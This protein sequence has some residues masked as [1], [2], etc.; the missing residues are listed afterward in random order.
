MFLSELKPDEGGYINEI[1]VSESEKRLLTSLGFNPG[2]Y[3]SAEVRAKAGNTVIYNAL[4][5]KVAL[6]YETAKRISVT[7]EKPTIKLQSEK[8][9]GFFIK[10]SSFIK[11]ES[12]NIALV[13]NQ[14]CGKSTL[15]NLITGADQ[16][17]GNFPGVTVEK[18]TA[19]LK[20]KKYITVTDLP[21]IYSLSPI[22]T[23]ERVTRDFIL[24]EK[25]N[26]I[27]NIIDASH[28][29]R[30]LNLTFQLLKLE[31][32][33]VIAL[34]M[35]DEVKKA[36]ITIDI[37]KLEEMLKVP[38]IPISASK[39]EGIDMLISSSD[40]TF[41]N[42]IHHKYLLHFAKSEENTA[43]NNYL[44]GIENILISSKTALNIPPVFAAE[45][46]LED[47]TDFFGL[48]SEETKRCKDLINS[49]ESYYKKEPCDVI[50]EK[51][52]E[53][54]NLLILKAV[55]N[56]DNIKNKSKIADK[57]L[58]EK[59]TSFII[60]SVIMMF[61]LYVTF[62]S[63]GPILQNLLL[64]STDKLNTELIGLLA[65][66]NVNKQLISLISGGILQGI[67]AVLSFIPMI[68]LL[69]F[70]LTL[71]ED[72]GYLARIAFIFDGIMKKVN[73]SGKSVVPLLTG[74]GCSVPAILAVRTLKGENERKTTAGLIPFMSCSAKL[75]V[76]IYLCNIL[77]CKNK[78]FI[79]S[80]L[81]LTGILLAIAAAAVKSKKSGFKNTSSF[82]LEIPEYRMP[83]FKNVIKLLFHKTKDFIIRTFTVIFL[84]SILFWFL[85]SYDLSLNSCLPE[86]SILSYISG[87]I[88]P[89]FAP[90]GLNDWRI[91]ASLFAGFAAKENLVSS[92][93]IL[94]FNSG[95]FDLY[96][97]A[98]LMI[99]C[100]LYSPCV[101]AIAAQKKE[102]GIKSAFSTVLFQCAIAYISALILRTI[103]I[104]FI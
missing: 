36:G 90:I 64:N 3:I 5:T 55:K 16:H 46:I 26:G 50:A 11:T 52:Y 74:F 79:I 22:T 27:I 24:R 96:T 82:I 37:K 62:G 65:S 99:F 39:S 18:K 33:V 83:R 97:I 91:T 29:N 67:S 58:C 34:N 7:K 61:I 8:F 12:L 87:L 71:L 21:G 69:L 20:S 2:V 63:L 23:E 98:P 4:G 60:F 92:L 68:L 9:D 43:L 80:M 42:N 59:C 10:E 30:G 104:I 88:S 25:P 103:L 78:G 53:F 84:M 49:V 19:R 28:L 45:K 75:P 101:A 31:I 89:A 14:N 94:D 66:F 35:M 51:R 102:F 85:K 47:K 76:F 86:N 70:F 77:N 32:P 56:P 93:E 40:Y 48:N 73:L 54:S 100:L 95:A 1:K 38:V 44:K 81:Y 17:I 13:G 72:S 15:F 57:I 6:R 41:K